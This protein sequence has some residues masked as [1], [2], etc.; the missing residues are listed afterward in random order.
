MNKSETEWRHQEDSF[1]DEIEYQRLEL[2]AIEKIVGHQYVVYNDDVGDCPLL[3]ILSKN[4]ARH[5]D[6]AFSLDIQE[7][8]SA[9]RKLITIATTALDN[10]DVLNRYL[11][12]TKT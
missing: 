11:A 2:K 5:F 12:K 7:I 9:L 1:Q 4:G 10:N 8:D 6:E 3:T